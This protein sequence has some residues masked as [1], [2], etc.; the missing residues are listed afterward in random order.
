MDQ[1]LVWTFIHRELTRR[2]RRIWSEDEF[3][4]SG[5]DGSAWWLLRRTRRHRAPDLGGTAPAK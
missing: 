1:M 5:G 2:K 4:R 3:Y